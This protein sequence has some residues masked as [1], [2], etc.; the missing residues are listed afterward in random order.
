MG[1]PHLTAAEHAGKSFS[2]NASYRACS[3]FPLHSF[4]QCSCRH[5]VAALVF[6]LHDTLLTLPAEVEHIWSYVPSTSSFSLTNVYTRLNRFSKPCACVTK[7]LYLSARY[8]GLFALLGLQFTNT[9]FGAHL[10]VSQQPYC[11]PAYVAQLVALQVVIALME[12]VLAL[13]GASFT[14]FLIRRAKS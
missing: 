7:W 11:V 2:S 1:S 10:G 14:V 6:L 13:R 4:A 3:I 12:A 8:L 9:S 5:A